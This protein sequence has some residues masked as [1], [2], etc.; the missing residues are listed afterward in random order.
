MTDFSKLQFLP[1]DMPNPPDVS[2]G[3]DTIPFE[4]MNTDEYR[5]CF[6]IPLMDREG[7]WL[8][9]SDKVP[10]LVK[11]CEDHLFTWAK[12]SR[13]MVIT[14]L[15]GKHNPPHIDCSPERF[16]TWQH[17]FRFVLRGNVD[18]LSFITKKDN[19]PVPN[20][21]KPYIMSGK[22]P[23][24]MHNT[25]N[26]IKYTLALGAPWEP[27]EDDKEYI[28]ILKRSYKK[29]KEYYMSFEEDELPENHND[30]YERKYYV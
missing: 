18:D 16:H 4:D 27:E 23:H 5:N 1:I 26:G 8:P 2:S 19:K 15:P 24:E 11:W 3:L 28:D 9:A 22:W 12:K 6:H 14:T 30:L 29:Y 17:K 20:V 25:Y 10:E 13:V 7:N 21:N